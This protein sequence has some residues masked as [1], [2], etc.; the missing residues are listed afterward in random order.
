MWTLHL[1]NPKTGYTLVP[2]STDYLQENNFKLFYSPYDGKYF[3]NDPFQVLNNT[4]HCFGF[5]ECIKAVN[6]DPRSFTLLSNAL[7]N[8][9]FN[10]PQ[11]PEFYSDWRCFWDGQLKSGNFFLFQKN[12]SL[13]KLLDQ[14]LLW[15]ASQGINLSQINK[16]IK[17]EIDMPN[18]IIGKA[19]SG[20]NV[21][22]ALY[23]LWAGY[24]FSFC[25]FLIECAIYRIKQK[26]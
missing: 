19:L 6:R 24:L 1:S 4:E 16:F 22:P 14:K 18:T 20:K 21:R 12:T 10:N 8:N 3:S 15:L 11:T 25:S 23:V 26:K 17:P 9:K 2:T 7:V 5:E 13:T